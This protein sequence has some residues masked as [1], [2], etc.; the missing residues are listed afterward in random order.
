LSDEAA[1]ISFI[2]APHSALVQKAATDGTSTR[3]GAKNRMPHFFAVLVDLISGH[4]PIAGD[5]EPAGG[6]GSATVAKRSG[7]R[8]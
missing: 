1:G 3:A 7:T 4:A 8:C 5:L 2:Q 6:A